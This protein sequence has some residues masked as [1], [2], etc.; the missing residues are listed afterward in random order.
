MDL[1]LKLRRAKNAPALSGVKSPE[2]AVADHNYMPVTAGVALF[3]VGHA[4]VETLGSRNTRTVEHPPRLLVNKDAVKMGFKTNRY[5]SMQN[6][7]SFEPS[8]GTSP[9]FKARR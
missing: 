3:G 2:M 7:V 8:A 9:R 1:L 5:V 6:G 4:P